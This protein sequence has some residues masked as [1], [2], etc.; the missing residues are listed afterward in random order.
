MVEHDEQPRTYSPRAQRELVADLFA[1]LDEQMRA[2]PDVDRLTLQCLAI[3]WSDL[4]ETDRMLDLHMRA[5]AGADVRDE[6]TAFERW[7][8]RRERRALLRDDLLDDED[9]E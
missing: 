8:A 7:R 6:T 2:A 1:L 5:L 4:V 9:E 3:M